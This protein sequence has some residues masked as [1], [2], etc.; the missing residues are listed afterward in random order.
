M[1]MAVAA[2]M[3]GQR[4]LRLARKRPGRPGAALAR[5]GF[6]GGL[7]F[8]LLGLVINIGTMLL[9]IAEGRW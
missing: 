5:V 4:G 9:M 7:I 1:V 6:F 2:V 8:G 3:L